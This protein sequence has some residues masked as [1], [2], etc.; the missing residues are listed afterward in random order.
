MYH[1]LNRAAGRGRLFVKESDYEAFERI[2]EQTRARVECRLLAYCLMPTHWHF[3]LWPREDDQ[4]S[5]FLRLLCVTH[6]QRLHAHRH[7]A[8][9]GPVYQGRFK[10]FPVQTDDHFLTVARYVERNPVR[11]GLAGRAEEWRWSSLWRR[12]SGSGEQR[13][14]LCDWPVDPPT[15]WLR[16]VNQPE[17]PRQL[18]DLRTCLKRGRPYGDDSWAQQVAD[19]LGLAATLR[20]MGRPRK[21]P[22]SRKT[23]AVSI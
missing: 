9:T 13:S 18:D 16:H 6:A 17:D 2:M 12:R 21:D 20:P 11:A 3:L 4:L 10:S 7:S 15:Q 19:K 14:L 22:A 1:V 23:A 5:E 8:G